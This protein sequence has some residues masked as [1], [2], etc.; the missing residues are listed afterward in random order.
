MKFLHKIMIAVLLLTSAYT[1]NAQYCGNSGSTICTAGNNLTQPGFSPSYDSLPCVVPGVPYSQVIQV[2]IPTTVVSGG[3][4]ATITTLKIDTISN[5]PCGLCWATENANN[6]FPGGSQF[7]IKVTGTTYDNPGQF[8]LHIIV[9]V[10]YTAFGGLVSGTQTNV[11]A[12]TAGLKFWA[13]VQNTNG[14]CTPVD[15]L[16]AGN[17][18][19]PIGAAPSAAVTAS[20]ALSFCPGGSVTF[21]ATQTG[22]SYQWYKGTAIIANAT[23]RTYTTSTAGSYT[24]GVTANCQHVISTAQVV[25][26]SATAGSHVTPLGPVVLCGGGTQVLTDTA[27]RGTRQ[28]FNGTTLLTATGS[29]YTATATGI[30][31]V[32]GTSNGCTDT[33]NRV[34]VQISTGSL[35]PTITATSN[36]LCPGKIDTLDA[37]VGYGSYIWSGA[38]GTNHAIHIT[39]AGNYSVTVTNG[40][41]SGSATVVISA[42][43]ATPTPSIIVSAGHLTLCGTNDSVTLTTTATNP[44]WSNLATTPSITEYTAGIFTVSSTGACGSATSR[45][46]TVVRGAIPQIYAGPDTGACAGTTLVLTAATTASG[47]V[48]SNGPTTA[49]NSVTATGGYT[50]TATQGGCAAKDSVHVTFDG[51]PTAT[52]TNAGGTLTAA[53][54]GGSYQWYQNNVAIS[55]ATSQVYVVTSG[56]ANYTVQVSNGYCSATSAPQLITV[57]GIP[58]ISQSLSTKIYPNPASQQVT[59]SYTLSKEEELEINLTD[60]TG[61]VVA[62]LYTGSQHTGVYDI[63]TDLSLLSGGIYF[64]QFRSPEGTLVRKITKD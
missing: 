46:D 16:A 19:T 4:T 57:N 58:D 34:N 41:C 3:T 21:T 56:S 49:T 45:P 23:G 39:S 61:R 50:V 31:Y 25:T 28:W 52:F 64:V 33:S 14:T 60:M 40:S 18:S 7:C 15:T 63:T 9:D 6:T 55:G 54:G 37:G 2:R 44:V 13:R 38:L 48:W 59:I 27:T 29:T 5:L 35:T 47:I 10:A 8:K 51:V 62:H 17:T 24:V 26:L 11:D 12:G 1:A 20:G 42:G 32:V 30:Y 36:P 53:S 43:V 22:A